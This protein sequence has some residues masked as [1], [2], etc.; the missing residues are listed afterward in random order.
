MNTFKLAVFC[1]AAAITGVAFV[2]WLASLVGISSQ[3]AMI[4]LFVICAAG[5]IDLHINP[6]FPA[7]AGEKA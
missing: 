6:I 3:A 7:K 1:L 5:L 2:V 4:G